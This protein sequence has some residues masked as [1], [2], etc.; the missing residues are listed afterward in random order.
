MRCG[1]YKVYTHMNTQHIYIIV[2][3]FF[4]CLGIYPGI[5][6]AIGSSPIYIYIHIYF[7][8][9]HRTRKNDA[10]YKYISLK[11]KYNI[12]GKKKISIYKLYI[13]IVLWEDKLTIYLTPYYIHMYIC[14][15]IY[16]YSNIAGES[17][18]YD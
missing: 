7:I 16:I 9:I 15:Y 6:P 5:F 8:Y 3:L 18:F 4:L 13:K 12:K 2:L 17:W 11:K 10:T 1:L 14:T